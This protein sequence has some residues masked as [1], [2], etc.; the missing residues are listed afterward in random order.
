MANPIY[1]WQIYCMSEQGW[2]STWGVDPP[3]FCPNDANHEVTGYRQLEL[4]NPPV[5]QVAD[6]APDYGYFQVSTIRI[7]IPIP[8]IVPSTIYVRTSFPFKMAIWEMSLT[9]DSSN[10]GDIISIQL[11]ENTPA[12]YLTQP[13]SIGD[14][15]L[16]VHEGFLPLVFAG[17]EI[18][19]VEPGGTYRQ[20][21]GLITAVDRVDNTITVQQP[22]TANYPAGS[23]ILFST[24]PVRNM[25]CDSGQ[26]MDLGNKGLRTRDIPANTPITIIYVDNTM[27][28]RATDVYLQLQYYH[29]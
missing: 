8:T 16:N 15:T 6:G 28:D 20:Y 21:P 7:P 3:T 10:K 29:S 17:N 26:R 4:I 25:Y 5:L 18:G 1:H 19:V 27:N 13:A 14:T 2:Q 12:S 22:L 11:G 9:Q 23:P 24:Y